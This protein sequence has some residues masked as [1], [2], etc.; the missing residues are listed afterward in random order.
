MVEKVGQTGAQLRSISYLGFGFWEAWSMLCYVDGFFTFQG[1]PAPW[2]GEQSL[3]SLL[4]ALCSTSLAISIIVLA[5]LRPIDRWLTERWFPAAGGVLVAAATVGISLTASQMVEA[6]GL[7]YACCIVAGAGNAMLCLSYAPLIGSKPPTRSFLEVC[8]SMMLCCVIYFIAA[9]APF[10]LKCLFCTLCPLLSG[11]FALLGQTQLTTGKISQELSLTRAT[12]RFFVAVFVLAAAA[13]LIRSPL[14]TAYHSNTEVEWAGWGTFTVLVVCIGLALVYGNSTRSYRASYLFYPISIFVMIFLLVIAMQSQ[15]VNTTLAS[16]SSAPR[17]LLNVVFDAIFFYIIYQSKMSPAKIMGLSHGFK[18]LGILLGGELG[19][20]DALFGMDGESRL[21]LYM[22]VAFCVVVSLVLVA[23]NT[24]LSSILIPIEDDDAG[25][26]L[27][28][29]EGKEA[30]C[31]PAQPAATPANAAN[32]PDAAAPASPSPAIPEEPALKGKALWQKRCDSVCDTFKL[33]TRERE[34]LHQ[35]SLGHG[36]EYIAE[37]LVISLYTA[38]THVRN[39]YGKTGVHSR[40]ELIQL[41]KTTEVDP[42][43]Y[44][45]KN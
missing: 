12:W 18:S 29:A 21:V 1:M 11:G 23:P 2:G 5:C 19:R 9:G 26:A 16:F 15:E 30:E 10:G 36:S 13:S 45:P 6:P 7:F 39:I 35:L 41:I 34:V 8:Y 42:S 28:F 17:S 40:E 3:T 22:I 25:T 33:T 44:H 14:L 27:P 4:F 20:A 37:Q 32:G 43:A 24:V 38:R 31:E